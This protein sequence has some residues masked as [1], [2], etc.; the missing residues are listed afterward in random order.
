MSEPEQKSPLRIETFDDDLLGMETF[1]RSLEE[2]LFIDHDFV[3]GSLVVSLNAA[4]GSGKST[5]LKMWENDLQS[6]REREASETSKES[7]QTPL[8]ISLNAWESDFYG[9]PLIPI[10]SELVE[11]IEKDNDPSTQSDQLRKLKTAAKTAARFSLGLANS[12]V[13][14][15]FHVDAI[16][17]GKYAIRPDD[18]DLLKD[19]RDRRDALD[20]LKK[21]LTETL[22]GDSPKAFV[23]IDELDRCRPDYAVSYLETIKHVFDIHGLVFVLAV[24]YDHLG[25]SARSLYGNDL[26]F[27]EY[28]RKFV[29]RSFELPEAMPQKLRI[30]HQELTN[31][32]LNNQGPRF[33]MLDI[34][35][36]RERFI[37]LCLCFQLTPRQMIEVFRILGHLCE[38]REK[39]KALYNTGYGFGMML[40]C[41]LKVARK[42]LY[43]SLGK[44][45][46][47]DREIF[48]IF[49]ERFNTANA[50]WWSQIYLGG[51]ES[52]EIRYSMLK[53]VAIVS[54]QDD[55][56]FFEKNTRDLWNATWGSHPTDRYP[57]IY[58]SLESIS[59]EYRR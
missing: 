32:Y 38:V 42:D 6:R 27:S 47:P 56:H 14:G 29:Q 4:F 55:K 43:Q 33:S 25:N 10:I 40:M 26:K 52:G 57:G 13:R 58:G 54:P 11:R 2:Y 5:A 49:K 22:G 1:C 30:F 46:R 36:S 21:L 39:P 3:E 18:N 41:I 28:F 50:V 15:A 23:F 51:F 34:E 31:F 9:E 45:Q 19:Y 24:D 35:E 17:A 53:E 8:V 37:D 7:P 48:R 16:E 59:P 20:N 12:V 44:R